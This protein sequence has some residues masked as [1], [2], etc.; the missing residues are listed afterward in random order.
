METLR[1]YGAEIHDGGLRSPGVVMGK[2]LLAV[3]G[4]AAETLQPTI[5][6]EHQP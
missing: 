5:P 3:P 2:V 6:A 4:G 1:W